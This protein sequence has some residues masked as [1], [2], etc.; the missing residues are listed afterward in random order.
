MNTRVAWPDAVAGVFERS[1]AEF[2]RRIAD[3][4][5]IKVAATSWTGSGDCVGPAFSLTPRYN[6]P[7]PAQF[8]LRSHLA[9]EIRLYKTLQTKEETV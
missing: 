3:E 4:S 2:Q 6:M 8:L 9:S 5:R 1:M 7:L